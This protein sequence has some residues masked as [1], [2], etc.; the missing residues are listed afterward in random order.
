MR[1]PRPAGASRRIGM[2]R[3][4]PRAD[5]VCG[6]TIRRS[7]LAALMLWSAAALLPAGV[8]GATERVTV[9]KSPTC[10]CCTLWVEHLEAAGFDVQ[11]HDVASVAPR[12]REHGVPAHLASCHTAVVG[13]YVVEGHVPA[14]DIRRLLE[15]RPDIAGLAVP[16]MPMGSPGMEFGAP[17][18]YDVIAIGRDGS[19]RVFASHG[20]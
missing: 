5:T 2:R 3:R 8:A 9:Y 17:E 13:G 4:T 1:L 19:S 12:K 18:P 16:G 20:R 7:P 15:Q 11:A 10:G 6:M 14:A